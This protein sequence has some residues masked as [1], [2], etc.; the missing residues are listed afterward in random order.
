MDLH[1]IISLN[2]YNEAAE[3]VGHAT[4][5]LERERLRETMAREESDAK[6]AKSMSVGYREY[7]V[8]EV[9][10][11]SGCIRP[12]RTMQQVMVLSNL[13]PINQ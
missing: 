9:V 10:R 4:T 2:L 7:L 11:I 5:Q 13:R 3:A 1:L 12:K 6:R 8:D